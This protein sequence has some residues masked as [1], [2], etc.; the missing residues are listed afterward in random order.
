VVQG[1]IVTIP[2]LGK[3]ALTSSTGRYTITGVL[4]TT[5]Q[6]LI[7]AIKTSQAINYSTLFVVLDANAVVNFNNA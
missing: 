4:T 1:A 2:S 5:T 7:T 3:Q 6:T